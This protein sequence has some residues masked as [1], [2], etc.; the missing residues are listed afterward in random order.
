MRDQLTNGVKFSVEDLDEETRRKDV[1]M[2]FTRGN[3]KLAEKHNEYLAKAV[4]KEI[5]RGWNLILPEDCHEHILEIV[6]N[7][8][9]VATHLGVRESGNFEL[10][11]LKNNSLHSSI[12]QGIPSYENIDTKRGHKMSILAASLRR[13]YSFQISS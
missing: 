7:P 8:M 11:H 6:L 4:T 2:A 10:K 9:G 12:A 1:Q 13:I 5:M 3:H